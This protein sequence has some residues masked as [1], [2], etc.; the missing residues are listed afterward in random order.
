MQNIY[1]GF[2]NNILKQLIKDL[3]E[4]SGRLTGDKTIEQS[5]IKN[6][7]YIINLVHEIR[8]AKIKKNQGVVLHLSTPKQDKVDFTSNIYKTDDIV[9]ILNK[10]NMTKMDY[11]ETQGFYVPDPS[12]TSEEEDDDIDEFESE[13][14]IDADHVTSKDN[15]VTYS[16]H[17]KKEVEQKYITYNKYS[18]K[19]PAYSSHTYPSHTYPTVAENETCTIHSGYAPWYIS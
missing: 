10:S 16:S 14:F 13:I 4:L 17:K 3:S 5:D 2:N 11:I 7:G 8:D 15:I 19:P 9:N 12:P 1:E 6:I 18:H